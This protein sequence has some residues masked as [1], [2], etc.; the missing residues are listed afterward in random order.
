MSSKGGSTVAAVLVPEN[1]EA[2]DIADHVGASLIR[3]R[4]AAGTYATTT[5]F[6]G[7]HLMAQS[8]DILSPGTTVLIPE[9]GA[10]CSPADSIT[11]ERLPEWRTQYLDAELVVPPECIGTTSVLRLAGERVLRKAAPTVDVSSVNDRAS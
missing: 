6:G 3:G 10:G 8:A 7:V 5:V 4:L 11:V 1:T 9:E 2:R